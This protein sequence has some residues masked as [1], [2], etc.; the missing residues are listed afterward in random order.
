MLMEI[1]A[2]YLE[3][4]QFMIKYLAHFSLLFQT[5]TPSLITLHP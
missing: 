3:A 4:K 2:I 5:H 1:E